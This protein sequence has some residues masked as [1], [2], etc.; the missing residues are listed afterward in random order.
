MLEIKS[1][2]NHIRKTVGSIVYRQDQAEERISWIE[3][4]IKE[5]LYSDNNEKNE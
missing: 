3:D 2:I 4:K 1:S 5:I